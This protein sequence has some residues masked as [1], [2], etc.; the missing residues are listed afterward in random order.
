MIHKFPAP[1][2]GAVT[3][4]IT[5]CFLCGKCHVPTATGM[6]PEL[7]E[8]LYIVQK[9]ESSITCYMCDTYTWRRRSIFMRDKPILPS[10]RML[11][12]DYDR[13]G[14]VKKNLWLWSSR[15]LAPRLI[16]GK[17][18]VVKW[19]CF[20]LRVSLESLEYAISSWETPVGGRHRQTPVAKAEK[21]PLLQVVA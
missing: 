1:G 15:D 8:D 11:H 10:E 20:W 19:L 18:P 17:P 6:L 12:K 3:K 14:S 13:K 21:P 7:T 4:H 9:Q 2:N 5:R 16:G